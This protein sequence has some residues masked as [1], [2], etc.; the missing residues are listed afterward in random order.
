MKKFG[1]ATI[2]CVL[3]RV[4]QEFMDDVSSPDF[5][6][7]FFKGHYVEALISWSSSRSCF[8]VD[9]FMVVYSNCTMMYFCG[10]DYDQSSALIQ[11]SYRCW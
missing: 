6:S 7:F 4:A 5:V 9:S 10:I 11:D 3:D 1:R 8:F 2:H